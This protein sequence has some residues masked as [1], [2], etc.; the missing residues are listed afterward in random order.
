MVAPSGLPSSGLQNSIATSISPEQVR[1]AA[2]WLGDLAIRKMPRSYDGDK[3]WGKTKQVWAGVKMRMDGLKLKTHRRHRDVKHGRWVKYELTVA[4]ALP[5]GIA[6]PADQQ[7][8]QPKLVIDR[9]L[10]DR[11]EAGTLVAQA[12]NRWQ[13]ESTAIL[14]MS[15][16]TRVQRWNLG[17]RIFSVTV[18]GSISLKVKTTTSVG[19]VMDY[20]EIPPALV[21]DPNVKSADVSLQHF[22]VNRVSHVGGELAQGWGE[23]VEE[24]LVERLVKKQSDRLTGK[25]NQAIDKHRDELRF[26][27]A[28]WLTSFAN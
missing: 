14:P 18:N 6:A 5:M 27:L 1:T 17:A 23:I 2:Q 25:L 7:A 20:A 28:D 19:F 21:L 22:K 8:R 9:V 15:F 3:D 26:S 12:P 24:V 13:I 4:P 16:T 10:P 11:S